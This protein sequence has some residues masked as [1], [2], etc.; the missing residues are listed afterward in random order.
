MSGDLRFSLAERKAGSIQTSGN[1]GNVV[2]V[3]NNE[4]FLDAVKS[5]HT[6]GFAQ[7]WYLVGYVDKD[8]IKLQSVGTGGI[9]ELVS[10]LDDNQMQ[11][12]ILRVV[13]LVDGIPTD[14]YVF[15]VW[16]GEQVKGID[17]ARLG[18][19]KTAITKL[20][21]HYNV[22]IT[23]SLKSELSEQE[24]TNKV[25]DASGSRNRTSET[26][27]TPKVQQTQSTVKPFSSNTTKLPTANTSSVKGLTYQNESNIKDLIQKVKDPRDPVDWV[28]IGYLDKEVLGLVGSGTGGLQDLVSHLKASDVYYGL[29]KVE[30]RIDAT[31]MA[32]LAYINFVGTSVSPM[33]KGRLTSHKG[34]VEKF[35]EPYHVSLF[36]ES[37]SD[38]T[39]S[40]LNAKIQALKGSKTN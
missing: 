3:S 12:A 4:E 9:N 33:T 20:M 21:G 26:V 7:N 5:V 39:D 17:K 22:E 10:H 1:S 29:V 34:N 36:G 40:V 32:K 27:S 11:Y 23:A 25:S 18:T 6:S 31:V 2:S 37:Q 8:T 35:F 30:D 16:V 38:L 14:R 15:I 19:N 24:I 28:L 13:D